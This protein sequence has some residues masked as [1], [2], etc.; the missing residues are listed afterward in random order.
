M[1]QEKEGERGQVKKGDRKK[2]GEGDREG[3]QG[4]QG[5]HRSTATKQLR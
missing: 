3:K 4:R 1:G 2:K 5:R